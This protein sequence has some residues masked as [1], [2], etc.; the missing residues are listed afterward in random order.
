MLP[1]PN[2]TTRLADLDQAWSL[3]SQGPRHRAVRL[4]AERLHDRFSAGPRVLAVRTLPLATLPYPTKYAFQGAA[5][6]L[7]PFVQFTH[8]CALVQFF[9]RGALK[10]LLFN[11]SDVVG[12]RETPYFAKLSKQFGA[13]EPLLT[14]K[15]HTL[16]A[17]LAELGL[18]TTDIDYVAFDHFHTQDVRGLLGTEDGKVSP[19]FPNAT[20]LAPKN[21]WEAWD[22]VHP[23]QR[24]WFVADG[25][26]G[27][28]MGKVALIDGDLEL[29]DGLLLLRT[30]GHTVGNQT[31]FFNTDGGVWGISE[32][33]TCADNWSP[34]DSKIRGLAKVARHMD[35]DVI[36]NANTPESGADQY[37]S[38]T[39][40][41]ALVSRVKSA[42]AFVQ[43]FPSSEVTP[44]AL[45][46]I[47]P[48]WR[49][50]ELAIGTVS[51]PAA[52]PRAASAGAAA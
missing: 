10:N 26:K 19:R 34:Q 33:G 49:H 29:G 5:S 30:P 17:Q 15:F 50:K 46:P 51:R 28:R 42:P 24:A 11:P 36:L 4:A 3:A 43:M 38:M 32:N 2:G 25:R 23:L 52:K 22:D 48:T 8:R 6:A 37:T 31:L 41:K 20:L 47:S 44:S 13:L 35:V 12:A 14:Q 21:E 1:A 39:L 40:E 16:E 7:S 9:Q 18:A 27:V 45:M